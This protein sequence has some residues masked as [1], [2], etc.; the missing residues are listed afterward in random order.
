MSEADTPIGLDSDLE[1][2][3]PWAYIRRFSP[4]AREANIMVAII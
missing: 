3:R 4:T 1:M 2:L